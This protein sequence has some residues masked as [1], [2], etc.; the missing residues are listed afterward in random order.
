MIISLDKIYNP[1]PRQIEFHSCHKPFILFGGAYGGGKMLPLDTPIP[2]PDGWTTMGEIQVGDQVIDAN[3]I[4][5]T[6]TAVSA[7]DHNPQAWEFFFD[8]HTCIVSDQ[9]HQWVTLTL[10]DR[11][12][13]ARSSDR[14]RKHRRETRTKRGKGLKPWLA[15][16]NTQQAKL[17]AAIPDRRG[18]V[19]TTKEIVDT[20]IANKH[21]IKNHA[22]LNCS[23]LDLP[24]QQFLIP[25]YTLGAWLGDGTALNGGLTGIDSEV[26]QAIQADGYQVSHHADPKSHNIVGLIGQLRQLGLLG[27][28]HIPQNYLR[29][30][31][32]QRMELLRGLCDTD[33]YCCPNKGSI[34]FTTTSPALRDGMMELLYSLGIKPS[35][36]E[37][38]A[39][40][41]GVD[42]GAKWRIQFWHTEVCFKIRRKVQQQRLTGGVAR[43]YRMI[44]DARPAASVP[45][46][47]ISVASDS[48]TYLCGRQMVPTHNTHGILGDAI[49]NAIM[50][51]GCRIGIFRRKANIL[52]R[53]TWLAAGAMYPK[54]II[55]RKVG[56][57]EM[58]IELI[59]GSTI[60]F[61]GLNEQ[62]DPHLLDLGS[63]ELSF[64]YIEESQEVSLN[65][66]QSV[67]N[68]VGRHV[69]PNWPI[70]VPQTKLTANPNPGWLHDTFITGTVLHSSLR[71]SYEYIKSRTLDNFTMD[72]P[73]V[74]NL[75]RTWAHD[76]PRLHRMMEGIWE[77][78][79]DADDLYVHEHITACAG[80]LVATRLSRDQI[81][82]FL[83][84]DL[85]GD[86]A[87]KITF[88]LMEGA[89]LDRIERHKFKY[90]LPDSMEYIEKLR[91]KHDIPYPNIA[92]DVTGIGQGVK[93]EYRKANKRA[94]LMT[95]GESP[96]ML[97]RDKRQQTHHFRN[98][99]TYMA[100][101][102]AEDVREG[103]LGGMTDLYANQEMLNI[104]YK[105]I[106]EKTIVVDSR[107]TIKA[108]LGRSPDSWVALILANYARRYQKHRMGRGFPLQVVGS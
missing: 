35:C 88:A 79:G 39:T 33:G 90:P 50:Y 62:S 5:T 20:L 102:L 51:P 28:K 13:L 83:G 30:S 48:R 66:F 70:Y 38:R 77:F 65:A 58:L 103:R 57:N 93:D 25:P 31:I 104:K 19:K 76:L 107:E 34:E 4:P 87:D 29:G 82:W 37:G 89:N 74:Q 81:P 69:L 105:I 85:A 67:S 44:N 40:L 47:C 12:R 18:S 9:H 60:R 84:V 53:T 6:V 15:E 11:V 41:R 96:V 3:G 27:N 75:L 73:Y 45:M 54:E 80:K 63:L 100:W 108:K 32:G 42:H 23:P 56:G 97:S 86:G 26:W 78:G 106:D 7:I 64:A 17:I 22:I 14:F 55:A 91:A 24:E 98:W 99:R 43:N 68:R 101:L 94:H 16:R 36:R 2:T 49:K 52:K 72:A 8:D 71:S 21:G 61:M 95:F 59:N 1:K 46:R 10:R 92:I